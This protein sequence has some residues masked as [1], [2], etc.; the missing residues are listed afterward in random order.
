[1]N[2][3]HES[4]QAYS[5]IGR[6]TDNDNPDLVIGYTA[7]IIIS[8]VQCKMKFEWI[9][10]PGGYSKNQPMVNFDSTELRAPI[11]PSTDPA[12]QVRV[13]IQDKE[14]VH[15]DKDR[16]RLVQL[17]KDL[18]DAIVTS[19]L[20]KAIV[21]HKKLDQWLIDTAT[22]HSHE[23]QYDSYGYLCRGD[24]ELVF[25]IADNIAGVMDML[26]EKYTKYSVEQSSS[27]TIYKK[28]E[29]KI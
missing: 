4:F 28:L 25:V 29:I 11:R 26:A 16:E 7:D 5:R 14:L 3:K 21:V 8:C 27:I 13:M 2:C 23:Q 18:L 17:N 6:L 10:V 15:V 1:M 20:A 24:G 19:D 9:G 12:E 22:A